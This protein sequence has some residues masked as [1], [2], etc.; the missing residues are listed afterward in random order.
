[1]KFKIL[2]ICNIASIE[3]AEIDFESPVLDRESLFLIY[4]ETGVGK[5]TILD[6]ICLALYRTT[7]RIK[8]TRGGDYNDDVLKEIKNKFD[9]AA[10]KY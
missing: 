8:Q 9:F 2:K 1:M 6:S 7:P 3:Y 4:G 10:L 5:T